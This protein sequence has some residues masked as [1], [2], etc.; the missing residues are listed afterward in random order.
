MKERQFV[1][2]TPRKSLLLRTVCVAYMREKLHLSV[3]K[4]R[5]CEFF[6]LLSKILY[7]RSNIQ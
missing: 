3:R 4:C 7:R 1:L 5:Y 6:L 2:R